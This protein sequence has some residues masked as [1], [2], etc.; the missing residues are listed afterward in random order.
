MICKHTNYQCNLNQHG[1]AESEIDIYPAGSSDNEFKVE[2]G[3]D[4]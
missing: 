3:A 1:G 2:V 4:V